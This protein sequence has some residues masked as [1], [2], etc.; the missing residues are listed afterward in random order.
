MTTI[1]PVSGTYGSILQAYFGQIGAKDKQ[2]LWN[3]FLQEEGLS[4]NPTDA[5]KA[6]DFL[7]FVQENAST[8]SLALSPSEIAK[9]QIMVNT[10]KSVL[11]ML[12][13]LQNTVAVQAKSLLFLSKLQ[14]QY[15]EMLS[16]VPVYTPDPN[17]TWTVSTDPSKF[18]FGYDNISVSDIAN[19]L[20]YYQS[21]T[22]YSSYQLQSA[23]LTN[24]TYS[25]IPGTNGA[26]VV[27]PGDKV[28]LVY[29]INTSSGFPMV[30]TYVV[31]KT[32]S[33]FAEIADFTG[34]APTA[35][36][37]QAW[38]TAYSAAIMGALQP[39]VP[40]RGTANATSTD[41]QPVTYSSNYPNYPYTKTI[42]FAQL[43]HDDALFQSTGS[44]GLTP[45]LVGSWYG[46]TSITQ[47]ITYFSPDPDDQS[48]PVISQG[49]TFQP[50]SMQFGPI[51]IPWEYSTNDLPE[52]I[53]YT[54]GTGTQANV[55]TGIAS[56][57]TQKQ[58]AI[59]NVQQK[60]GEK[61]AQLQQFIQTITA[62]KQIAQN[63][64]STQQ[65]SLNSVQQSVSNQNNLLTTIIQTMQG[66]I[67]SIFK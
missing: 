40:V 21:T 22:N 47:A 49:P 60:I 25:L 20:G 19:Y 42:T 16:Q 13:T 59:T 17:K 55:I 62:K 57:D 46:A 11:A 6:A 4:A 24:E 8:Q 28:N 1:Y 63:Q 58:Q 32:T 31:N 38:S 29:N 34:P 43:S 66:L 45:G 26:I 54:Y 37:T 18:T 27:N 65:N 10:F 23:E 30:K 51:Y 14:Q 64:A 44:D 48:A 12:S 35:N 5:T 33:Q 61:N 2:N 50:Q 67:T 7:A 41:V 9:R 53:T 39:I 15:T 36:T 56:I 3:S 52:A